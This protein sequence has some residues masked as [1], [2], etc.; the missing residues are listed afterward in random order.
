M[1]ALRQS[2]LHPA[3]SRFFQLE[4]ENGL[5]DLLTGAGAADKA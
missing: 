5:V 4:R 1:S 3:A 2:L